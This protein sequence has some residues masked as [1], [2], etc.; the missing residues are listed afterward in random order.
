L[1]AA[2]LLLAAGCGGEAPAPAIP[3]AG[4][5]AAGDAHE[6]GRKIYNFR[7]YYCHGYAGDARTLA[8]T[9]LEPRPRDFTATAPEALP[10]ER[11][12]DAVAKGRPGTAMK[13]FATVLSPAE[14]ALVVD[15]VRRE[16]MVEKARN[17]RYH[18]AANGWPDHERHAAAFPFALGE[19][20]LDTPW[21]QLTPEQQAGK[22]LFLRT[23]ITCHDRARVTDEGRHWDARPL[24]YPRNRYLPG[25][26]VDATA[27]ASPYAKHEIAPKIEGLTREERRGEKLFQDNC[28]FCHA[29]DG[30]G[31]NWIGSFLQPHPRDLTD[32]ANMAAMSRGRLREVIRHGLPG[33]SMPAWKSVLEPA[34]IEA[35]IAYV[36]R[37]FH[38]VA[39]EPAAAG[40]SP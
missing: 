2:A 9:Y 15:F 27:G 21:E 16:F 39:D 18:T 10:R 33:T 31:R 6:H 29:A 5:G 3:G 1:A 38:P 20:A 32:P 30:T 17:T 34:E 11:M 35:V 19:L 7:C 28:A 22:R 12:L 14:I 36:A 13:G 25:E 4:T 40:P 37:A 24:S 26:P 8:A 23:C